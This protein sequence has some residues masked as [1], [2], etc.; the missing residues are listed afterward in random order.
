M[1]IK[2]H[3]DCEIEPKDLVNLQRGHALDATLSDGSI[4]FR[5][6]MDPTLLNGT[7]PGSVRVLEPGPAPAQLTDGKKTPKVYTHRGVCPY[8]R[9][10]PL[11]LEPHIRARHPDKPLHPGG[12]HRCGACPQRFGSARGLEIHQRTTHGKKK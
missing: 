3:Y 2:T 1:R 10:G 11:L 9:K 6:R 5:F 8:C 4:A 7:V 12:T